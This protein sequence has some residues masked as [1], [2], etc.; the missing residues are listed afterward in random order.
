MKIGDK[1]DTLISLKDIATRTNGV[2]SMPPM[3]FLLSKKEIRDLV[4]FLAT[5]KDDD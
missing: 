5:L 3:R 1:P 4:S 2:S